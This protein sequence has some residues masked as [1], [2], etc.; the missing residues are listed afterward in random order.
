MPEEVGREAGWAGPQ[1]RPQSHVS[2]RGVGRGAGG[3]KQGPIPCSFPKYLPR[4]SDPRSAPLPPLPF[5]LRSPSPLPKGRPPSHSPLCESCQDV[6]TGSDTPRPEAHRGAPFEMRVAPQ[7]FSKPSTR[8]LAHPYLLP[9]WPGSGSCT[10]LSLSFH[11][12]KAQVVR[13]RGDHADKVLSEGLEVWPG[14][15]HLQGNQGARGAGVWLVT[16]AAP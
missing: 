6:P 16:S 4:G 15:D 11:I 13:L 5:P 7:G 12:C 8:P 9:T 3:W 1:G 10:L 14:S 2:P